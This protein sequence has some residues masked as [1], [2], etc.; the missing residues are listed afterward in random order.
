M[1]RMAS[2]KVRVICSRATKN[3]SRLIE[4]G[5]CLMTGS[6]IAAGVRTVGP[7]EYT[8]AVGKGAMYVVILA[9]DVLYSFAVAVLN[10]ASMG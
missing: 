10:S 8:P 4:S 9:V 6:G 1:D 3:S 7:V 2:V 5:S